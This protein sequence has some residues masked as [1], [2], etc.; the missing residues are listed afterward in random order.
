MKICHALVSFIGA[1]LKIWAQLHYKTAV[2]LFSKYL[3]LKI[4]LDFY[5]KS[6][7]IGL[8][9]YNYIPKN[10]QVNEVLGKIQAD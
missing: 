2:Y 1:M 3:E 6:L 7:L 10:K 9:L 4:G 5:K 8:G